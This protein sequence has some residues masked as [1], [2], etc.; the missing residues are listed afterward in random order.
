MLED[1]SICVLAYNLPT[2]LAEQPWTMCQKDGGSGKTVQDRCLQN[3]EEDVFRT[4]FNAGFY[5][6]LLS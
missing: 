4:K 3:N 5:N 6:T 2:I 1:R